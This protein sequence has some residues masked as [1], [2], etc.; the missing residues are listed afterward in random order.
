[1]IVFRTLKGIRHF[2]S[3]KS[4]SFRN[5]L[6]LEHIPTVVNH[7][8]FRKNNFNNTWLLEWKEYLIRITDDEIVLRPF[9]G[10][11]DFELLNNSMFHILSHLT[12]N[13][14]L[15]PSG[16][17]YKY[18]F[19]E[20]V[21][22]IAVSCEIIPEKFHCFESNFYK[23]LQLYAL[24]RVY[25]Q[26][27]GVHDIE[28]TNEATC[29]FR[30]SKE[31]LIFGKIVGD[32]LGLNPALG[33]LLS[34]TGGIVGVRNSNYLVR[35]LNLFPSIRKNAIVH[36]AAGYLRRYHGVGPGYRYLDTG[37]IKGRL[38]PIHG[39]FYGCRLH[40]ADLRK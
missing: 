13:P 15:P 34:P 2:S 20:H 19:K 31:H 9:D 33:A 24:R 14:I 12:S 21:E 22:N 36:D 4:R 11:Y 16:E 37:D 39:L 23:F 3:L 26:M 28:L 40:I 27:S 8:I 5:R 30:A 1:M 17:E 6:G 10:S 35:S 7:S 38:T 18:L 25:I 29:Q 32:A